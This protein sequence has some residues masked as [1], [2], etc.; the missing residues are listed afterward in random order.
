MEEGWGKAGLL[1]LCDIWIRMLFGKGFEVLLAVAC[2][3]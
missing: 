2:I 1:S 3:R